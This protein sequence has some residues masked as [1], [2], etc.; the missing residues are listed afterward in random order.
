MITSLCPITPRYSETDA[1]GVIYHANYIIWFEQGRT[2]LIN[3]IGLD[4]AELEERG[5]MSPVLDVHVSY[6][7]PIRYGEQVLIKT[8]IKEHSAV[9]TTYEYEI[10]NEANEVC[11]TGESS[12]TIVDKK[13]FRP[14]SM[15]R[16]VSD[17][18]EKLK[19]AG[20]K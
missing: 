1:M 2:D 19:E 14:I 6:K 13:T 4:Y 10:L 20:A 8:N 15:K 3:K 7:R 18:Y 9:K 16:K 5:F 11:V 17:W 12:H